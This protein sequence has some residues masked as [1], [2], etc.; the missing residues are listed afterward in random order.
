MANA[1]NLLT[2]QSTTHWHNLNYDNRPPN[3]NGRAKPASPKLHRRPD[4]MPPVRS[5][6]EPELL[7]AP[8]GRLRLACMAECEPLCSVQWLLNGRPLRAPP[9]QLE[10]EPQHASGSNDH[11][12]LEANGSWLA[13]TWPV[14]FE[15][16]SG[17]LSLFESRRSGQNG[18]R[19]GWLKASG[20]SLTAG[21]PAAS[22]LELA[23]G[24]LM[25]QAE[26]LL[27][28]A[29]ANVFSKLELAYSQILQLLLSQMRESSSSPESALDGGSDGG[30]NAENEANEN[31]KRESSKVEGSAIDIKCKL[32]GGLDEQLSRALIEPGRWFPSGDYSALDSEL[33]AGI[34]L[35]RDVGGELSSKELN[36]TSEL[37]EL[38]DQTKGKFKLQ[39]DDKVKQNWQDTQA[40][41]LLSGRREQLE[42]NSNYDNNAIAEA[43]DEMQISII[44][45]SKSHQ[46]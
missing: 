28:A 16:S 30:G 8:N 15:G 46:S 2:H 21:A 26:P 36:L 25:R 39:A 45:D 14:T 17:R 19:F 33:A 20:L 34:G 3:T 22:D 4:L 10:P 32:N 24:Q 29:E 40:R 7:A 42:A 44:L 18:S 23:K 6:S 27:L 41:R 37:S 31:D 38:D 12:Q 11:Q 43:A 1:A 5:F 35:A 9:S 13:S